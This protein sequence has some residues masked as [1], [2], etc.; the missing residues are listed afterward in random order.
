MRASLWCARRA[1]VASSRYPAR[2]S[3][4]LQEWVRAPA[5]EGAR[6]RA[7]RA[8]L[9]FVVVMAEEAA[10]LALAEALGKVEGADG[11]DPTW[12]AKIADALYAAGVRNWRE[13]ADARVEDFIFPAGEN[14]L[15]AGQKAHVRRA[16]A[17]AAEAS[18]AKTGS[19]DPGA[20]LKALLS[21]KKPDEVPRPLVL[22]AR[23]AISALCRRRISSSPAW[24]P[25]SA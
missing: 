17:A 6:A 4:A 14:G 20:V 11:R 3:E 10:K 16:L 2:L 23:A 5:G 15:D 24:C 7:N 25:T 18:T 12:S 9:G 22:R 21:G 8:L 19:A 13:L 1:H